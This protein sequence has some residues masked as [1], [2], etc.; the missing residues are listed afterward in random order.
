MP[1]RTL[2]TPL[3][4]LAALL[5]AATAAAWERLD[6]DDVAIRIVDDRGRDY[7]QYP[8]EGRSRPWVQ[9]AYLEAERGAGY[10]IHVQNLS[11]Y[12][13]GLVI[14]VDGRN[15]ISGRRSELRPDERMYVLGPYQRAVY[16][17]WRTG[18]QR[19]NRFYFTHAGDSY[20]GAFGDYSAMGVIAVAAFREQD[21]RPPT[22][23]GRPQ[24][25]RADKRRHSQAAPKALEEPGTGFGD[26]RWS[27][28]RRVEFQ[29]EHQPF[30][31]WLVKYE[32]R[33]T[34]CRKGVIDC[35]PH[36]RHPPGNRFWDDPHYGGYAPYPPG[37]WR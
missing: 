18:R 29:P 6:A 11:P 31:R 13:I 16:D 36:R 4:A 10:A 14:A 15:I 28:S 17:G 8:A 27:P 1:L 37:R 2:L 21:Y 32:W 20:A 34:L 7:A 26:E 12:R 30:G 24:E 35:R 3:L 23:K 19:V 33:E 5:A 9:K 22:H 25:E